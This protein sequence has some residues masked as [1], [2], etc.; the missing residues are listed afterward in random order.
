MFTGSSSRQARVSLGLMRIPEGV[1]DPEDELGHACGRADNVLRSGAWAST[2]DFAGQA[3][4]SSGQPTWHV[5]TARR[6]G[7][8]EPTACV[9][10]TH[11]TVWQNFP[12]EFLAVYAT[13]GPV[14]ISVRTGGS[15]RLIY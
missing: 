9:T 13:E 1:E 3:F 14:S 11:P 12:H 7:E 4:R 6:G 15:Y 10:M 8:D 2:M 5:V